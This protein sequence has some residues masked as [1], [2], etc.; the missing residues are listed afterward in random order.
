MELQYFGANC[1]RIATK[2]VSIVIDDNLASLGA[3]AITKPEDVVLVTNNELLKVADGGRLRVTFPGEYEISG[4]SV[5]GIA[6]K[7]HI[8]DEKAQDRAVVYRIV[9]DDIRI[10]V[11]GHITPDLDDDRLEELGTIDVLILPVGGSGYTLDGIE[12]AKLIKKIEPRLIIPTH[13]AQKGVTYEVPQ[14]PLE[15]AVKVLGIEATDEPQPKLK[16][17]A[18]DIPETARLVVLQPE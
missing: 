10:G 13:Y 1:V 15:E 14:Q 2:K 11:L 4:A 8:A 3:K 18:V 6:T 5:T 9:L 17:R 12:A 16:L 7:A